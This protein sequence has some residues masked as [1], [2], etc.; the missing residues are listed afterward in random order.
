[1]FVNCDA[2]AAGSLFDASR[3]TRLFGVLMS[4]SP[5]M[6]SV[7]TAS[8]I[9]EPA[10]A[11]ALISGAGYVPVRSPP[12]APDGCA[13]KICWLAAAVMRPY[14]SIVT[15]GTKPFAPSPYVPA[16]TPVVLRRLS[17]SLPTVAPLLIAVRS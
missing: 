10:P 1:M 12:A 9:R 17:A 8:T 15:R 3:T 16:V 4:A 11:V 6:K 13:E 14:W 5:A 2:F 7:R